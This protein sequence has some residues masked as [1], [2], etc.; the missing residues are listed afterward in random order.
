MITGN[1]A[2][3]QTNAPGTDAQTNEAITKRDHF[4]YLP[5]GLPL[6]YILDIFICIGGQMFY[7]WCS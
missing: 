3:D 5:L 7:L 4:I 1:E 6:F 2:R